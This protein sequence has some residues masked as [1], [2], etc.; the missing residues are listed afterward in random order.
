MRVAEA[1]RSEAA[2]AV[3]LLARTEALSNASYY[4]FLGTHYASLSDLPRVVFH[5]V[6]VAAAVAVAVDD[7]AYLLCFM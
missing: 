7:V 6:V 4:F 2:A 5:V 3:K 1:L